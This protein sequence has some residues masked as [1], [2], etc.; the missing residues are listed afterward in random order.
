MSLHIIVK[1]ASNLNAPQ[2]LF[3]IP[4]PME[5]WHISMVTGASC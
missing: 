1:Y 3:G 4:D 2:I 5:I